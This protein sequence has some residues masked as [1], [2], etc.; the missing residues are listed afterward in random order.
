MILYCSDK[1]NDNLFSTDLET[2]LA[3]VILVMNF[4]PP[5]AQLDLPSK[6]QRPV[7]ETEILTKETNLVSLSC[8]H[9][10]QHQKTA[11]CYPQRVTITLEILFSSNVTLD[12][13]CLDSRHCSV[14]LVEL[15]TELPLNVNVSKITSI[16]INK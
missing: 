13:L 12:S 4:T 1:N 15:G 10:L 8:A 9:L 5:T 7:K 16:K 14:H 11:N 6:S 2:S 3:P